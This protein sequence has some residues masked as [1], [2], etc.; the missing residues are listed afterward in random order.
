VFP[1]GNTS[2]YCAEFNRLETR[3][4]SSLVRCALE[5]RNL[6]IFFEGDPRYVPDLTKIFKQMTPELLSNATSLEVRD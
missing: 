1:V 2:A 6:Y 3:E 5:D 4:P